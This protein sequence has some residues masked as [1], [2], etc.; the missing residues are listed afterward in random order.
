MRMQ[1]E[2][3][4]SPARPMESCPVDLAHLGK[5]TLGNRALDLEILGLFLAQAPETISRLQAAAGHEQWRRAAHTLKGSARGVGAW[6]LGDL[7]YAAETAPDWDA[8]GRRQAIVS[9]IESEL[10][11]V[12]AFVGGLA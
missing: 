9:A 3:A 4:P 7:A 8:A 6:R 5:Y 10:A 11:D 1:I 2:T 12:A